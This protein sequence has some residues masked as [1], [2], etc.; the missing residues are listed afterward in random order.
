V[1]VDVAARIERV[2]ERERE[3]K[4]ER[5]RRRKRRRKRGKSDEHLS[6]KGKKNIYKSGDNTPHS[7]RAGAK[8]N[9]QTP[10]QLEL[11]RVREEWR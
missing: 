2:Q 9:K 11:P 4:R 3:F 1:A 5:E 6:E 8:T 10:Y 7:I